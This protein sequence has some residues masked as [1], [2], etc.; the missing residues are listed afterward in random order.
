MSAEIV[1][2]VDGEVAQRPLPAQLGVV[3]LVTGRRGLPAYGVQ[4]APQP[5][6][7]GDQGLDHVALGRLGGWSVR[8]EMGRHDVLRYQAAPGPGLTEGP[9]TTVAQAATARKGFGITRYGGA[10]GICPRPPWG[11]LPPNQRNGAFQA[12]LRPP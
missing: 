10:F 12:R 6:C 7:L 11:N 8:E 9:V 3:G 2:V 4:A 1:E 5:A